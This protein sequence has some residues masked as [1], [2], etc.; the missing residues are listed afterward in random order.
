MRKKDEPGNGQVTTCEFDS[1]SATM[2]NLEL[3]LESSQG[4][5]FEALRQ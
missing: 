1:N 3:S 4:G 5:I 2:S